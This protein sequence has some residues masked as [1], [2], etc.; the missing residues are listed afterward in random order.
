[1]LLCQILKKGKSKKVALNVPYGTKSDATRSCRTIWPWNSV[2]KPY[3]PA[4]STEE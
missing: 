3:L 2:I 1:M 4:L